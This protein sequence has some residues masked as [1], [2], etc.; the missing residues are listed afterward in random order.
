MRPFIFLF[1]FFHMP[2][3]WAQ[4]IELQDARWEYFYINDVDA[5]VKYHVDFW[6]SGDTMIN[7]QVFHKLYR[8][9]EY[10]NLDNEYIG[11][12]RTENESVIFTPNNSLEEYIIMDFGM[13]IGDTLIK[14]N[15]AEDYTVMLDSLTETEVNGE[16]RKTLHLSG[17]WCD[18]TWIEGVGSTS[19]FLGL[20]QFCSQEFSW[21]NCFKVK[22]E[23]RYGECL[24]SSVFDKTNDEIL[25]EYDRQ[26]WYI[27][28]NSDEAGELTI[29]DLNGRI[30]LHNSLDKGSS[31]IPFDL[32]GTFF[33]QFRSPSHSQQLKLINLD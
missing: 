5:G 31:S 22:D 23:E 8:T 13:S 10:L 24:L 20:T 15:G 27:H 21:L 11:G 4:S 3:I 29:I 6:T 14:Y 30:I 18:E 16:M 19:Y 28:L 12:I 26:A 25:L 33:L 1:S 17:P 32:R 2:V 9:H 7:G